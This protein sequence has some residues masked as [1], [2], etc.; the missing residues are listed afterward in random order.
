M[1][2]LEKLKV[3]QRLDGLIRRKATGNANEL[4]DKLGIS[5]STVFALLE[6]MKCMGAE[7]AFSDIR[8]TYYYTEDKELAIGFVSVNELKGGKNKDYFLQSDFFGLCGSILYAN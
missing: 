3:I 7:I 4:A 8:R 2:F 6:C 1:T 5:R